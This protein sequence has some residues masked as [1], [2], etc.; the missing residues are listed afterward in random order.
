MRDRL[1]GY[2]EHLEFVGSYPIEPGSP[3]MVE[4]TRGINLVKPYPLPRGPR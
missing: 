2:F 3:V 4:V 1:D